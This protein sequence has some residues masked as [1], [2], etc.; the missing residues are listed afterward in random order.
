MAGLVQKEAVEVL[1]EIVWSNSCRHLRVII[2]TIDL[3]NT[4]NKG[5]GWLI[6]SKHQLIV[7]LFTEPI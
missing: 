1:H 7:C 6:K 2:Q 3:F 5:M 4:P